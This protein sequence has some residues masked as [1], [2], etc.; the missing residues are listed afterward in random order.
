MPTSA[1]SACF[2]ATY[3][4]LGPSSPTKMVPN[5]TVT[6]ALARRATRSA[7]SARIRAARSSP[8]SRVA[9]IDVSSVPEVAFATGHDHRDT[10]LVGRRDDLSVTNGASRLHHCRHAR[11]G[12]HLEAVGEGEEGITGRRP[13]LSS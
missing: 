1:Q 6:P 4:E 13:T 5:P 9:V 3:R 10:G 8:S 7:T 11:F 12:Q 2:M